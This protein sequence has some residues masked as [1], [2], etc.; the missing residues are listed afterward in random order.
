M[1]HTT[2]TQGNQ[3]DSQLLVVKSQI[4]NLTFDPSFGQNFFKKNAQMGLASPF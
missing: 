4:G 2:C 3:G 1:W